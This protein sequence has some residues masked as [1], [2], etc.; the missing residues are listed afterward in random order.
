MIVGIDLGGTNI[1][2]GLV[3]NGK[4]IKKIKMKTEADKG[5]SHIIKRIITGISLIK[6]GYKIEG[7]GIGSPGPLDY[8]QGIIINPPNLPFR[9]F[10]LKKAIQERFKTKV[11]I[12][13]DAKCAALAEKKYG[14]G[15]H[16]KNFIVLTIGTGVGSGA[17]LDGKLYHGN[18]FATEM[19]HMIIRDYKDVEDL[20]S[21]TAIEQRAKKSL[22]KRIEAKDLV[23]SAKLG[24]K[25]AQKLINEVAKDLA[26]AFTNLT[27]IFD[28]ELII[29]NGG[30]KE[31]G[32]YLFDKAKKEMD[33]LTMFEGK[34]AL[35]DLENAGIL[36]A[37]SLIK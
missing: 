12:E 23:I 26:I 31:A 33:K 36:G 29:I 28:P 25:G 17:I 32:N 24:N 8:K 27:H 6:E 35:S 2:F 9:N 14:K 13:N 34:I 21:G 11:E 19:G 18:M 37:A 10:N 4:I 5:S 1:K 3:D 7:I 30:V 16:L 22:G 20:V 15:K